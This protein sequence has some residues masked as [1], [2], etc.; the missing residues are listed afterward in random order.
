MTT[1]PSPLLLA[2]ISFG[3]E[4]QPLYAAIAQAFSTFYECMDRRS[5]KGVVERMASL[6]R[7]LVPGSNDLLVV[8]SASPLVNSVQNERPELLEDLSSFVQ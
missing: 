4:Y 2:R 7:P 3:E 8:R 1:T 5:Q 6:K